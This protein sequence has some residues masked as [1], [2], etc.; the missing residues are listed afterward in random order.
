MSI[1]SLIIVFTIIWWVVI[2]MVLPIGINSQTNEAGAP[3]KPNLKK[4][5]LIT[6]LIA[7][8]ITLGA[9]LLV[10]N[11]LLNMR[12]YLDSVQ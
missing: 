5:F 11:D 3:L 12:P 7:G 4:K 1:L 10:E 9:Y 2:F 8:S 6:T